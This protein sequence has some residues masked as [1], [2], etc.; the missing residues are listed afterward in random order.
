MKPNILDPEWKYTTAANSSIPGYLKRKFDKF[1][2]QQEQN[3]V[4][5]KAKVRPLKQGVKQ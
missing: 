3:Q 4:E 5:A 1:R 2:K